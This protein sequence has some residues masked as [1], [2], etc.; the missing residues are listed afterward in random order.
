MGD[1][2]KKVHPG[3]PLKIPAAAY[4]AFVE[5]AEDLARRR[6]NRGQGTTD[7]HRSSGMVLVKNIS[8]QARKRFEILGIQSPLFLSGDQLKNLPALAACPITP[9]HTT[10]FVIL[11]EPIASL[12][13]GRALISGLS[14]VQVQ[15]FDLNHGYAAAQ[16]SQYAQLVSRPAGPAQILWLSD[17]STLG[18]KWAIVRVGVESDCSERF[19][20]KITG[21]T[22]ISGATYRWAYTWVEQERTATGWQAKSGGRTGTSGGQLAYNSIEAYNTGTGIQG[23]S[24]D[25][26]AVGYPAGFALLPVRGNPVV[27]MKLEFDTANTVYYS[28]S[29]VNGEDGSCT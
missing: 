26:G 19:W 7:D 4:N 27:E 8:G 23:N 15:L 29:Y 28:F 10:K 25:H 1:Y 13:M 22:L 9:A 16:P 11:Q 20:A 12:G 3:Q 24:I 5:A 2:L 21:S 17:S 18:V 6:A 14:V